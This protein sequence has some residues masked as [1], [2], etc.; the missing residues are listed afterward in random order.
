M[1]AG[2]SSRMS[3]TLPLSASSRL[4]VSRSSPVYPTPPARGGGPG[5]TGFLRL[6]FASTN[7]PRVRAQR[8]AQ[9]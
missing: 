8:F 5:K 6:V 9:P 1:S 4:T 3:A 7:D 2:M